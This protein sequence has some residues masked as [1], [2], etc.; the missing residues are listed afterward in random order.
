MYFFAGWLATSAK[1]TLIMD[2]PSWVLGLDLHV[3]NCTMF[4]VMGDP[5]AE[6]EKKKHGDYCSWVM[7]EKQTMRPTMFQ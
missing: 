3:H 2:T 5:D 6:V 4:D 7:M 1:E